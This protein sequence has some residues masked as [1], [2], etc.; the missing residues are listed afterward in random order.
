MQH[1]RLFDV[2]ANAD[3]PHRRCRRERRGRRSRHQG[4]AA[5]NAARDSANYAA[6]NTSSD[7]VVVWQVER[8]LGRN[9]RWRFG[10]GSVK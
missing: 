10:N 4:D 7:K 9:G 8:P 6:F 5:G 1:R 2:A 3:G